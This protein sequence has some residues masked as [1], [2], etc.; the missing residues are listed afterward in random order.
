ML[1]LDVA[2]VGARLGWDSNLQQ[3]Q[4]LCR[5]LL[6]KSYPGERLPFP[7]NIGTGRGR[8]QDVLPP[9]TQY[10]PVRCVRHSA[11]ICGVDRAHT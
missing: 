7:R 2:S 10:P 9:F 11:E 5:G 3:K 1:L 6:K 4:V 8:N